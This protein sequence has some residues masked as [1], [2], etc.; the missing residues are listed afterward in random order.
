M[1]AVTVILA[2][3]V[4]AFVLGFGGALSDSPPNTQ[5]DFEY[6]SSTNTIDVSHGS[7]EP[8]TA[9]NT[10]SLVIE[11]VQGNEQHAPNHWGG[12]APEDPDDIALFPDLRVTS[13][14][15]IVSDTARISSGDT[16]YQG[17]SFEFDPDE[18]DNIAKDSNGDPI[19][20][21]SI[22]TD[23]EISLIWVS[24]DAGTSQ[25]LASFNFPAEVGPEG[26]LSVTNFDG[27]DT[28]NEGEN[29]DLSVDV[30]NVGNTEIDETDVLEVQLRNMDDPVEDAERV[31][32]RDVDLN[33]GQEETPQF[34]IDSSE[35]EAGNNYEIIVEDIRVSGDFETQ[36][37]EVQ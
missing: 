5:I 24:E 37:I 17:D 27:P 32:V 8:L 4:G 33:I 35:F 21:V 34:T 19:R 31:E 23:R 25:E 13:T 36:V 11:G 15:A 30:E 2:A 28:I 14:E 20:S 1:V 7:G 16:I 18:P 10:G 6:E 12:V 3:V 22:V 29:Y 9:D 26:A